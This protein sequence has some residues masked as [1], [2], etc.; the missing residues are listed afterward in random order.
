MEGNFIMSDA[1]KRILLEILDSENLGNIRVLPEEDKSF[2]VDKL[3]NLMNNKTVSVEEVLHIQREAINFINICL[4]K[5]DADGYR[6]KDKVDMIGLVDNCIDMA[7]VC[8]ALQCI[9][10]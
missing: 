7:C 10:S 6:V 4:G 8:V 9:Y 2:I 3:I 1:Y 5:D